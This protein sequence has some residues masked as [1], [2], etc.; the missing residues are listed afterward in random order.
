MSSVEAEK[1]IAKLSTRA[2]DNIR[3]GGF[4]LAY[5]GSDEFAAPR[6]VDS[7]EAPAPWRSSKDL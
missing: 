3:D 1:I 7:R 4:W 5:A 6:I 2:R